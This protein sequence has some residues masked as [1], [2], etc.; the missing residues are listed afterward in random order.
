MDLVFLCIRRRK[1]YSMKNSVRRNALI[2]AVLLAVCPLSGCGG[3]E[4]SDSAKNKPAVTDEVQPADSTDTTTAPDSDG[5]TDGKSSDKKNSSAKTTTKAADG[6]KTSSETTDSKGNA[7]KT[8]S[9]DSDAKD[10]NS[11]SDGADNS[12][13][14]SAGGQSSGKTDGKTDGKTNSGS[15]KTTTAK[16]TNN[17]PTKTEPKQTEKPQEDDPEDEDEPKVKETKYIQLN[18]TTAQ[19]QGTGIYVENGK[20]TIS[21]GGTYQISGTLSNGQIYI[22]TD[23][24]K[25]RLQLAG[26]EIT[27]N[28]GSAINCQQAKKLT[29]ETLA[30]TVNTISDGGTHD[31]DKGA[32]F[33][34]DTVVFD[35][36]GELNINGKYAHGVQSDDDIVVN[37]GTLNIVSTKSGLHSNDGIDING[38]KLFCDGGTNG[39]KTDGYININGGESI[40]IGGTR[41]EKGAVYCDGTFAVNGGTLYAIGNTCTTPDKSV[42]GAA[43]VGAVFPMTQ[44]S[45]TVVQF[46]CGGS[47][48]ATFTSPRNFKYAVYA[49]GNLNVNTEYTV[50]YGGTVSGGSTEHFVTQGG[51]YSGG[52]DGGKLFTDSMVTFYHVQS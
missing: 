49:G 31:D 7:A 41:E 35:G 2:L 22:M 19:Y 12:N 50:S 51:A 25:V 47:P 13:Q 32:I 16:K 40:F 17:P 37:N 21:K 42:C 18:G 38:G 30:G 29:I 48:I 36:E 27:N 43:V 26:C 5:D 9:G 14:D 3:N 33:S 23:D 24:K 1:E 8:N 34:E 39:I 10:G 52:A 11:A 4:G 46:A 44:G 15:S 20:I 28:A 6:K 45:N